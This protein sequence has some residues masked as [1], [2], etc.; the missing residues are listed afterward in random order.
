M[1]QHD[2]DAE[3]AEYSDVQQNVR[4]VFVSDDAAIHAD[5]ERFLAELRDVLKYAA[6]VSGFHVWSKLSFVPGD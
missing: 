1:D 2:A 3:R 5:D 4:E 6:Q